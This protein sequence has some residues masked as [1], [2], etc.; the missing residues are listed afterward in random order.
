MYSKSPTG[1]QALRPSESGSCEQKPT[2]LVCAHEAR[3]KLPLSRRFG[4]SGLHLLVTRRTIEAGN[5]F[6]TTSR[7]AHGLVAVDSVAEMIA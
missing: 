4:T 6:R 2:Q 7:P 3:G 1:L 5:T